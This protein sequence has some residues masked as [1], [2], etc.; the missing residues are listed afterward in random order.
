MQKE[1]DA[2]IKLGTWSLVSFPTHKHAIGCKWVFRVKENVDGSLNRY[3]ARLVAKGF[4]QQPGVDY[5]KTFSV[6][7]KP[8]TIRILLTLAAKYQWP[9]EQLD[10]NNA[11]LNGLLNEEVYM[12]QPVGFHNGDKNV[13]CKLYKALYGLKQAPR[14][15]FKKLKCTIIQLG[16]HISR[17]DNSLFI[18]ITSTYKLFVLVYVDDIIVSGSSKSQVHN[19]IDKL[20]HNFA[21]KRL[22]L[23]DY[24]L[25]IEVT[26]LPDGSLFL[27]QAKHVSDLLQMANMLS[28]K[29][30]T[31]PMG[32]SCKLTKSGSNSFEDPSLYRSI[33]GALQYATITRPD[34]TFSVNKVCQFMSQP[35]IQHWSAVKRILRYLQG[36]TSFGLHI[37]PATSSIPLSVMACC[38]A[39]W[40]ADP[41]DRKSISGACVFIGP[42]IV[43]WWSKKQ[44]TV[45]RSSTEA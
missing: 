1:F 7:V 16:F 5:T 39:D 25:G 6:V 44:Q 22:G 33:V 18:L 42:T 2:L 32:T 29:P 34:L 24:F 12:V 28:A 37:R 10:V 31:T 13:V 43:T 38:D 35:R 17:C 36:F 21:L 41:D 15:W 9:L 45:S 3:K 30:S 40:A 19:I 8:I 20:S 27:S 14:Q 23:L 11:F 26:H 4:H